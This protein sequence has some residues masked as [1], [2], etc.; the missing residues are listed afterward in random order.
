VERGLIG[1]EK[2]LLDRDAMPY[3]FIPYLPDNPN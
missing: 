3:P 2:E 1:M